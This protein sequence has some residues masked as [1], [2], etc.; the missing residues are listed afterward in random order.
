MVKKFFNIKKLI[1]KKNLRVH[2][3]ITEKEIIMMG[4]RLNKGVNLNKLQNKTFLY[5][6]EVLQ[7]QKKGIIKM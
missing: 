3:E 7:L 6:D 2:F 1:L 4:L 5:K